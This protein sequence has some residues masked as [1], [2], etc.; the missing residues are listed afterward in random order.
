MHN[1]NL[2]AGD[3][4]TLTLAA[5]ARLTPTDYTD[6]QIW[7]INLGGGEP[8]ALA[9][10]TTFGLRAHWLRLFPRFIR[11]ETTLT[12]PAGFHAPPRIRN[13]YPNMLALT[14]APFEGLEVVAEYRV[15]SSNLVA[16]R[17]TLTNNS[18]LPQDFR[19]EWAGLL[20]PIDHQGGMVAAASGLEVAMEGETSALNLAVCMTGSPKPSSSP[21]PALAVDLEL[22]PGNWRQFTW[23][24][25]A[26]HTRETAL[27]TARAAAARPWEAGQA[28]VEMLALSQGLSIQTGD[29]D[30]DAAFAIAQKEAAK[31]L[32]SY[33]AGLPYPSFVLSRCPDHG[34]SLRGDG[35]DL[36]HLWI[37]QTAL[38]SYYLSSLLLPGG[39]EIVAGLLRNFLAVQQENG[40]IDWR[41]GL[42]GQRSHSLAQPLLA[43]LAVRCAPY[44]EQPV[45][46]SEV[47][48]GLLRF[49]N[50]WF[51]PEHDQDGDGFPEWEHPL[52]GGIDSPITDRWS[53]NA[54][55]IHV[56]RLEC[57]GL[58]AMLLEE[59]HSLV[60]MARELVEA[61]KGN[62]AY[63]RLNGQDAPAASG[64]G[65]ALPALLE[66]EASLR[67]ELESTWSAQK[68]I[69]AYRD[70]Q[71]HLS[72]PGE[73]IHEFS[74]PGRI[75][76][77]KASW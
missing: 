35:S 57:P 40:A 28:R 23:A 4:L 42:G 15:V 53:P 30:W 73:T 61:E 63:A 49:F 13:F 68:K 38:D 71:T 1:W 66:R 56:E 31:L 27:E 46:Y 22:Y 64:A 3:P 74:G 67:A 26:A 21:Y 58:A 69:Y 36:T 16:G 48:P 2:A 55:G 62:T 11:T 18:I 47:F 65:E 70:Y 24:A 45:W 59:C 19:L 14:F 39:A 54:Q 37:G 5:D 52:Q 10:Q 75:T 41:P 8:P 9:L 33:P 29:T 20:S 72:L 43:T 51:A 12:D 6:D 7:E 25:C 34:Y 76:S 32:L 50:L 60:Q 17:L 77:R 44:M